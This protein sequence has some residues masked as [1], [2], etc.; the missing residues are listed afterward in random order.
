MVYETAFHHVK[1]Q[2][3]KDEQVTI[4]N[5]L[6]CFLNKSITKELKKELGMMIIAMFL[7]QKK[8]K[9]INIPGEAIAKICEK[10][11]EDI[12]EE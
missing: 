8:R 9:V 2:I 5:S 10:I 1:S 6:S 7:E 4:G 11:I 12:A 3:S